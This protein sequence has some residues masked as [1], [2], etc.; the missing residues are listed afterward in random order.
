MK[1]YL[2]FPKEDIRGDI[3]RIYFYMSKKYNINLSKKERKMMEFWAKQHPV[4]EWEIIK[5]DRVKSFQGNA[6]PYI[7]D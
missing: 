6:N 7:K 1:I 2:A 3:A 4:S 5:N